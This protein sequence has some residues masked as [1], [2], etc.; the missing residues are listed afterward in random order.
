MDRLSLYLTLL[1]GSFITGA[2]VIAGFTLGYYSVWTVVIG[3]VAGFLFAWPTSYMISQRIKR[4]DPEWTPESDPDKQP[5]IQRP[6][7]PEV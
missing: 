5:A 3:A 6:N 1:S 7:A 2:I 4:Q